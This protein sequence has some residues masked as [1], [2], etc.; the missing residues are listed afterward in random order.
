MVLRRG[1]EMDRSR[2]E[3]F[4]F[5]GSALMYQL[6]GGCR[7]SCNGEQLSSF[8]LLTLNNDFEQ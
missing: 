4:Q 8:V 1:R 5:A 6:Y 3:T 7:P 2:F